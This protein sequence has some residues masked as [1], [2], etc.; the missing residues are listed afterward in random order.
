MKYVMLLLLLTP[1]ITY[2]DNT[3]DL[4]QLI[5]LIEITN[6]K[7]Y[8]IAGCVEGVN[9]SAT[10]DCS[11]ELILSKRVWLIMGRLSGTGVAN[12][13]CEVYTCVGLREAIDLY[14]VYIKP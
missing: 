12:K 4:I 8:E 6:E 9:P 14:A 2:A 3:E 10:S 7:V 5:Q 1:C 11:E 13:V